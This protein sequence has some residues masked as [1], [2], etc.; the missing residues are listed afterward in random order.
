MIFLLLL[1]SVSRLPLYATLIIFYSQNACFFVYLYCI[2][3][4]QKQVVNPGYAFV[5]GI[6]RGDTKRKLILRDGLET[7]G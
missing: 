7:V 5:L 6:A 4:S 1:V 3:Y 2:L